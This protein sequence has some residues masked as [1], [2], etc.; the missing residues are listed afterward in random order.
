MVSIEKKNAYQLREYLYQKVIESAYVDP[1]KSS[2]LQFL[3]LSKNSTLTFNFSALTL[4]QKCTISGLAIQEEIVSSQ[5]ISRLLGQAPKIDSTPMPWVSDV[6]GVMAIKWLVEQVDD[7]R[8][9]REF[10]LWSSGFLPQ[11]TSVGHFN[12]FEKDIATY[13]RDGDDANYICASVPLFL[14]YKRKQHIDDQKLRLSLINKFMNEFRAQAQGDSSTALLSLMLYVFDQI[15][16]DIA[17]VPPKG[18]TLKDLLDF[19]ENIPIGLRQ[20]TW[21]ESQRTRNSKPVKWFI[22][23]EYHVQNLLYVLLAPIFN[24]ISSE[25]YLQPIGQKTPRTD[26]YLPSLHVIIEVKYRKDTKKSFSSFIGEI[27]EDASL[28]RADPMYK[29]AY[30]ISFLWDCTRATQ[31]YAKFKEGILKLDGINGCVVLSSPS[32]INNI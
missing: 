30:I 23:N 4:Y 27:A 31:E 25:V 19:L 13:I 24:D 17:V 10:Y 5:D 28:Y 3:E 7:H 22:E 15:N 14:H 32:M 21:E 29:D 20:W 2:F 11:Q 9:D 12:L 6:F 16:Q 1:F 26:L 8:I 18:W